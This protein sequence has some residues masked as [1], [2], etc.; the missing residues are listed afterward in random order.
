M[1]HWIIE[2]EVIACM[3]I[4]L[5]LYFSRE[6]LLARTIQTR[7]YRS[8]LYFALFSI[9]LNIVS[10]KMLENPTPSLY[11]AMYLTS[12]LYYVLLCLLETAL[13]IYLLY[14]MQV[15]R[16]TFIFSS[17][18]CTVVV[19]IVMVIAATNGQ[20]G[21]M[22][23]IL[24]DGTFLRG[25]ANYI[26]YF[27]LFIYAIILV[28][29]YFT[30]RHF[31]QRNMRSTL[32]LLPVMALVMATVQCWRPNL[33][34]SGITVAMVLLVLFFR[35]Q[36]R[37]IR[38]DSLTGLCGREGFFESADVLFKKGEPFYCIGVV[39]HHFGDVNKKLGPLGA[40][41][42]LRR[43]AEY[44]DEISTQ[45]SA[46]RISGVEFVLL[47]P[48]VNKE[49]GSQILERVRRRFGLPWNIPQGGFMMEA[50]LV[51]I[52]CPEHGE[53]IDILA[54]HLEYS[55]R[56]LKRLRGTNVL[57]FDS[58]RHILLQRQ[59]ELKELIEWALERRAFKVAFQ[60]IYD[61]SEKALCSAEALL[62]LVDREGRPVRPDDFIPLAEEYGQIVEIDWMVLD[63]VC[64]FL[65]ENDQLPIHSISVNFSA[66]E[67]EMPDAA[68]RVFETLRRHHIPVE[69]I[70][71]ELTERVLY[72]DLPRIQKVLTDLCAGGVGLYLDDFGTGYSNLATVL[73]LPFEAIK[74]DK[75]L[76]QD[77]ETDPQAALLLGSLV[78]TFHEMGRKVIIEG[79]EREKQFDIIE[80]LPVSAVQGY[81]FAS[82]MTGKAYLDLL[83]AK[84]D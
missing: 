25:P 23:T 12:V 4:G 43:V 49:K 27:I 3:I 75:S 28:S 18:L 80:T 7:I 55:M 50:G 56:E 11:W 81:Y 10:V 53:S 19:L 39:L 41:Q 54:A 6:R 79:L 72:Q 44:L 38:T 2:A 73:R 74:I 57:E 59:T 71:I 8:S 17:I 65:E 58:R 15:K 32:L 48:Q 84:E 68:G 37:G 35:F 60:P 62:R 13:L 66:Q 33:L 16:R 22:F 20:T 70:K 77:I 64:S 42:L 31:V 69:K 21:L 24:E 36:S 61:C 46:C 26:N 34:M 51:G 63:M 14:L 78:R 30:R 9:I 52:R 29:C 76:L 5:I 83:G 1:N 45:G 82:P 67:L 47:L 40:D